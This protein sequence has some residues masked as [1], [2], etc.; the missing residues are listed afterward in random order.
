MEKT[1]VNKNKTLNVCRLIIGLVVAT[2]LSSHDASATQGGINILHLISTTE[3]MNTGVDPDARGKIDV[4]LTRMGNASQEQLNI[5]LANLD[6]NAAYHLTAFLGD[7]TNA[8]SVAG[9][10]ANKE[11]RFT[12][13][14]AKQDQGNSSSQTEQFPSALDPICNVR[15]LDVVNSDR[16][17]VLRAVLASPNEG[18]YLVMRSMNNTGFRPAA[19]GLFLLQANQ[20]STEFWLHVSGL[21]PRAQYHF[22]VN[23]DVTQTLT[24]DNTG[25]LILT[26]L[27]PGS[28]DA[29]DIQTLALTDATG[30]NI[31]LITAGLGMPCTTIGQ[32]PLLLG[33]AA[34][35]AVLAG[36]TVANT[37]FTSVNGNLGLS[38]GSAVTGFPP[39][40]VIGTQ[41]VADS[42]AAQAKLDLTTAY[43]D[44]AGLTVGAVSVSGNLGGLTLPPGL[45]K[46]TSSLEIS[47]GDLTLDAQGDADAVFIFQIASTLT[48]TSGRKVILSGG[49]KAGNIFWQVGSSA[50]LGTTSVFKGT[51]MANQSITLTTGA[52]LEGRA[53][54]RIAAVTLDSNTV[55]IPA[56]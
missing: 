39:G 34:H 29:L 28:P 14:Y 2:M 32:A 16:E 50:T 8:T 9:F 3:M 49:A 22:I 27:P 54:T 52:T 37:G 43:N 56:P 48:T 6:T 20:R 44:V 23:G 19:A 33:T 45:Y 15:E 53:L 26:A 21:A 36:S 7:E 31:V 17:I 47:S 11:G 38:P 30:T 51:I 55:A 42:T 5:S 24:A 12:V 41:Y 40:T 18:N 10:T 13:S 25:K 46:S 35:F 1:S 4:L